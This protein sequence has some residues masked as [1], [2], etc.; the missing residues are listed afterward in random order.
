[1]QLIGHPTYIGQIR[2]K[3]QMILIF[4]D[5][6]SKMSMKNSPPIDLHWG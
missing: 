4:V 2:V 3:F 5:I 6:P 1:M